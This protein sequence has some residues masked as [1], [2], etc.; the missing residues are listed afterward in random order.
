LPNPL[1]R[2]GDG[3][4]SKTDPIA[5]SVPPTAGRPR[6]INVVYDRATDTMDLSTLPEDWVAT[7]GGKESVPVITHCG[8]GGRGQKA[9]VFLEANGFGNVINGGGPEDAE[10]W[11]IFG[12]K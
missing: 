10:C 2:A 3:E 7:G 1:I 6:A 8:G 11:A 12:N 5:S 9:R 4:S